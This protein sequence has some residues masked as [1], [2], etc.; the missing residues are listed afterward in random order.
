MTQDKISRINI[1]EK[2]NKNPDEGKERNNKTRAKIVWH[3]EEQKP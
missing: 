2:T 3:V 1:K